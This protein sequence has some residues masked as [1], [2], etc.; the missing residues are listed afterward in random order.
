MKNVKR[1]AI[2]AFKQTCLRLLEGVRQDGQPI[3]ITKRGEP[4]AMVV[5]VPRALLGQDWGD[6]MRGTGRILGDLT[7]PA[8]SPDDW[9]ALR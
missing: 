9:E 6:R 7:A 5:P 3:L 2:G 4:V 8:T 1:I